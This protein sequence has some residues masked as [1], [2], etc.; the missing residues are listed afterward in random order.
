MTQTEIKRLKTLIAKAN[1][2]EL[3]IVREAHSARSSVLRKVIK[4]GLS[5]GD[6]VSLVHRKF[7]GKAIGEVMKI[8]RTRAEVKLNGTVY[9]VPMGMLTKETA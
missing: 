9:N 8:N 3:N 4:T 7:G 2:E 6:A 5:V 1:T